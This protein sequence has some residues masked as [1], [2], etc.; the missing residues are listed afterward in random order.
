MGRVSKR[1]MSNGSTELQQHR[2]ENTWCIWE[3]QVGPHLVNPSPRWYF[4]MLSG[5]DRYAQNSGGY[6]HSLSDEPETILSQSIAAPNRT[7]AAAWR[8]LIVVRLQPQDRAD[9]LEH[10]SEQDHGGAI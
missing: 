2:L 8:Y 6:N 10:K 3:H 5:L 4:K 7:V 9:P 1:N